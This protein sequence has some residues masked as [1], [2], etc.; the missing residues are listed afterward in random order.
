SVS[1]LLTLVTV[2]LMLRV[3]TSGLPE[4]IDLPV[5]K[6]V[7]EVA[8]FLLAPLVVAMAAGSRWPAFK[9]PLERWGVRLGLVL[10]LI[11][12]LGAIG[13]VRVHPTAYG[14]AAPLTIILFCV[15]GQQLNQLPFYIFGW[16]RADRM[17]AGMEVTMRNMNLALLLYATVFDG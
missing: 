17:A 5:D 2:P 8:V 12:V 6:I 4:D 15:L 16:S 7:L 13:S 1:T 14:W 10:V 11:M 9:K 3:L